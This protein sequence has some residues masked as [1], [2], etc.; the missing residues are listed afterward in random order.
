MTSNTSTPDLIALTA[1]FALKAPNRTESKPHPVQTAIMNAGLTPATPTTTD[2]HSPIKVTY[3]IPNFAK[4]LANWKQ[5]PSAVPQTE[6]D[7]LCDSGFLND[8]LRTSHHCPVCKMQ[9]ELA[10]AISTASSAGIPAKY[11][12]NTWD[13]FEMVDPIPELVRAGAGI[14]TIFENGLNAVFHGRSK[15]GKTY[16]AMQLLKCAV[17]AGYT[18]KVSQLGHIVQRVLAGIKGSDEETSVE[19]IKQAD[20]V[21]EMIAADFLLI[22]DLGAGETRDGDMERKVLYQV[23]NARRDQQKP[24]F[25]TSNLNEPEL[26]TRIGSRCYSRLFPARD[27]LFN[28][29]RDFSADEAKAADAIWESL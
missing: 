2:T 13:D 18:I 14:R 6:H 7:A 23:L 5:N 21:A 28:H 17:G 11:I 8:G 1:E 3:A 20:A 29:D 4:T 15:Q 12:H 24:T 27:F 10:K 22:D 19:G 25:V 16:A 26:A 9:K